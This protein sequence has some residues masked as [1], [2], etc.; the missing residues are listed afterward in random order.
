MKPT[1]LL[2]AIQAC[3]NGQ[4]SQGAS[5]YVRDSAVSGCSRVEPDLVPD[6]QPPSS[7][8][9]DTENETSSR[10]APTTVYEQW[11][12]NSTID[13]EMER[14]V[15]NAALF[16]RQVLERIVNVTLTLAS[17]NL[18]FRGHREVLDKAKNCKNHLRSTVGQERLSGL[19]MLSIENERAKKLDIQSIVEEFTDRK[20]RH[21]PFK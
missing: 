13:A 5:G 18:A 8:T 6:Q 19:A 11:K 3:Q 2:A 1:F 20:A 16:W 7:P 4:H 9:L 17:C 10:S 14:N 21:M 15:R 12:L